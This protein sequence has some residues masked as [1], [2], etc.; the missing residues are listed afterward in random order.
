MAVEVQAILSSS[1]LP[2]APRDVVP[3]LVSSRFV[4]LSWRPP[5]EPKGNIQIFTVFFSR[6][7]DNRERALNTTQPGS[8][9]F[10]VGNLKPEA[11]YTFRVVA[12][13]EWGPGESSQPIKVATQPECEYDEGR[14]FLKRQNGRKIFKLK[15]FRVQVPG[16]VENLQ[17]VSTSPTSILIT[18]EPPAYANGPVQGYRLFCTEASTGKEQSIEVD[19]LSYKLE[20]LKKFTEYTLRFLAYNR[21]GPGVSTDDITV[22]TFSDVPSAPPQNVSLEVVNSRHFPGPWGDVDGHAEMSL[23][24]FVMGIVILKT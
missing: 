20:G 19:G 16:P 9:Q 18:W 23:D 21:Y 1:I 22:V 10:T 5:A 8:L 3:V 13:N 2:S 11:M 14:N 17:A 6:E 24:Y 7:G 15:I 12:Y 4:R